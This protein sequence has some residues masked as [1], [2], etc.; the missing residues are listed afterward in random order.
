MSAQVLSYRR[1]RRWESEYSTVAI[2]YIN[3]KLNR[4]LGART[5]PWGG[6]LGPQP[7]RLYNIDTGELVW[8]AI[9]V[10]CVEG[11]AV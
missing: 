11:D 9:P 8:V 2:E 4:L 6:E 7:N 10:S 1:P 3:G 5:K